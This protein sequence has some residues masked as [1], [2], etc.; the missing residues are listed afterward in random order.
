MT[1][2]L[3]LP[4]NPVLTFWHWIDA[5]ISQMYPGRAYDGGL[6]EI[7]VDGGLNWTQITPEGGYPYTSR[8]T[9]GPFP[10]MTPIYSG[11]YD[12]SQAVFDLSG[13]SGETVQLRFRFGSDQGVTAEGWYI[14]DVLIAGQPAVTVSLEPDAYEVPRGGTLGYTVTVENLSSSAQSFYGLIDAWIRSLVLCR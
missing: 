3:T 6:V 9:T 7:S 5:E 14:D 2:E 10:E 13:Y 1:P 11:S 12:W 4:E 8:G